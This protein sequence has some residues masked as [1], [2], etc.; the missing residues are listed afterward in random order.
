M[1]KQNF[2]Q[3]EEVQLVYRNKTRASERPSIKSPN[4]AYAILN[5][6][7]NKEEINL[8]EESKILL[9]DNQLRL[10]SIASISKGGLSGTI[11]DPKIVFSIAL[12]RRAN[13]IILAHNH[14]CGSL[15]PSKSDIR[16]TKEFIKAG[17]ILQIPLEDHLILTEENYCSLVADYSEELFSNANP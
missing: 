10:M 15:K 17:E 7:W 14:P 4:D 1:T 8:L 11:V 13:R 9:L 5:Q 6:S 2:S 3:F 16:L 12:K